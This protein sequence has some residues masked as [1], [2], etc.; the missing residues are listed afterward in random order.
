[1]YYPNPNAG[2]GVYEQGKALN[3][4]ALNDGEPQAIGEEML[5]VMEE[6]LPHP[7]NQVDA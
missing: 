4:R 5:G 6:E 1:M 2:D 7:D 3:A